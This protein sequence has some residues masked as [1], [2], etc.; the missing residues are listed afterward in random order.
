MDDEAIDIHELARWLLI[1]EW[2]A[3]DLAAD[4]LFP[5]FRVGNRHRFWRSEVHAYLAQPRDAWKQSTRS[6]A[7]R[8]SGRPQPSGARRPWP[9]HLPKLPD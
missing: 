4:P 9:T 5:S 6:L 1:S 2:K 7:R 3:Y 8:R